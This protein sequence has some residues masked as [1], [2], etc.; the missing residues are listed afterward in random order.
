[1]VSIIQVPSREE[2]RGGT[3]FGDQRQ[4]V[5]ARMISSPFTFGYWLVPP[6]I[7]IFVEY[8]CTFDPHPIMYVAQAFCDLT[9]L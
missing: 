5:S 9:V 4:K 8:I 1:M 2:R 6:Y 7:G 3:S